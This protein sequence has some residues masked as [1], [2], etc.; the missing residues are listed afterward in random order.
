MAWL[1]Q[2]M[3]AHGRGQVAEAEALYLQVLREAGEQPDALHLLGV[4]N[5]QQGRLAQA[6]ALIER[7]IDLNPAEAMFH[8]NLGN[9]CAEAGALLEA[10][11]HYLHALE[12]DGRRVD[13][14]NNLG[15]LLSHRGDVNG[16]ESVLQRVLELAPDFRDASQNLASHH[17]RHGNMVRA[18]EAC[19]GGLLI[20]PR[21]RALRRMLGM[22]YTM[23]GQHTQAIQLYECWLQDEPG[24]AIAQ[25]HLAAAQ[26]Q[27][28]A[29]GQLS[30]VAVSVPERA[31]DGYVA[32]V[33]DTFARSFDERLSQLGYRAPGLVGDTLAAL[34][35]PPEGRL[36]VLDAGCGTGLCAPWLRPHAASLVGVDLSSGMLGQAKQRGGYDELVCAEL[37]AYLLTQPQRF[38]ALVSA[39]TLCYFGALHGF[40]H[41]A[42]Q[43]VRPGG[44]LVF[45]VEALTSDAA[46]PGYQLG[47]HGRYSHSATYL[48]RVLTEAGWLGVD[49]VAEVLRSECGEAVHGWVVSARRATN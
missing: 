20:A 25:H 18:V 9:V 36:A 46:G 8:N 24:N 31:A 48:R 21:N 37:V 28:L 1:E 47:G 26:A 29:E 13:A 43:A 34:L 17:L 33:F 6:R 45:T 22:A 40:A 32:Q 27:A 5:A 19:V 42:W 23:L 39:D 44:V 38:D 7:A 30:G 41:A 11:T 15:V 4:L 35:P 49:L 16:A 14:L 10:E 12:L 2:A 3:A